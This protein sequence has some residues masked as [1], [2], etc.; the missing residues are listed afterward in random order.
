[1]AK[2]L[3]IS[4]AFLQNSASK[5]VFAE[6]GMLQALC[7]KTLRAGF[8]YSGSIIYLL[9]STSKGSV[10]AVIILKIC[11]SFIWKAILLV[12]TLNE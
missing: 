5:G 10:F 1:M 9:N 7:M 8:V 4:A 6:I 12:R 3:N 2:Q 11:K